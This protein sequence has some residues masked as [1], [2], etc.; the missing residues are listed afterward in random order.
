MSRPAGAAGP[1]GCCFCGV[2]YNPRVHATAFVAASAQQL[3]EAEI[4]LGYPPTARVVCPKHAGGLPSKRKQQALEARDS[5]SLADG[6]ASASKR[7]AI[8]NSSVASTDAAS[9]RPPASVQ[10][11]AS[12]ESATLSSSAAASSSSSSAA[13]SSSSSSAAALPVTLSPDTYSALCRAAHIPSHQPP[14]AAVLSQLHACFLGDRLS[15][16]SPAAYTARILQAMRDDEVLLFRDH[17]NFP[18]RERVP[19]TNGLT[20]PLLSFRNW[21]AD[22]SMHVMARL[23]AL[24]RDDLQ[25]CTNMPFQ[26]TYNLLCNLSLDRPLAGHALWWA[27]SLADGAPLH[28]DFV[29]TELSC[30]S[31]RKVWVTV[32]YEEARAAGLDV[33]DVRNAAPKNRWEQFLQCPSFRWFVI[34]KGETLF[35]PANRLHGTHALDN[36]LS[37]ACGHYL[38]HLPSL[39]HLLRY[40]ATAPDYVRPTSADLTDVVDCCLPHLATADGTTRDAIRLARTASNCDSSAVR[41]RGGPLARLQKALKQI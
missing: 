9:V 32:K 18:K 7:Q 1:A 33:V 38:A 25:A 11:A 31:G 20:T 8:D 15:L 14:A 22:D 37:A 4:H 19:V 16:P 29:D 21:I 10:S 2:S 3:I 39:P 26:C 40:W 35:M 41:P 12:A 27:Q 34:A 23:S 17:P 36:A 5:D 6:A 28:A 13:A 24:T 30:T